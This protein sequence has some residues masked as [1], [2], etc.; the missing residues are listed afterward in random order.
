[1]GTLTA[2][3]SIKTSTPREREILHLISQELTTKEIASHLYLSTHTIDSHRKK[4]ME[5]WKV[6]N[7]A[8]LVRVGF[9]TGILSF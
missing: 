7:S 6:R 3:Y 1:M 9:E 5:K 8:G 4:L 2:Q